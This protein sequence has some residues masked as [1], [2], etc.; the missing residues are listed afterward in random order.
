MMTFQKMTYE[1]VTWTNIEKPTHGDIATLK[2]TYHFHPLALEDCISRIERPKI[3][4][5][6][7]YLVVVMHIPIFDHTRQMSR[8]T[9]IDIFV[10]QDYLV[11][12]HDG[13]LKPLAN[14]AYTCYTNQTARTHHFSRGASALFHEVV[15]RM[16]DYIFPILAK[17]DGHI[18]QLEEQIFEGSPQKTV[19]EISIIRRDIIALRRIIRPLINIISDLERQNKPF[20][21]EHMEDYFDDILDHAHKIWDI[22]EDDYEVVAALSQTLDSLLSHRINEVMRVLTVISITMLPLTLISGIYGMNVILPLNNHPYAFWVIIGA[23][24]VIAWSL[25]LYFRYQKWL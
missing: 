25:I 17:L 12:V 10:G 20:I 19:Q 3:D 11:T 16:V 23:M 6:D 9:E 15:D 4:M 24:G 18:T 7:E 2:Q 21:P 1:G 8:A 5:Y 13:S 22:L 14:F